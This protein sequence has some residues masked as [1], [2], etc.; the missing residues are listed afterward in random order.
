[1]TEEQKRALALARA[2]QRASQATEQPAQPDTSM[3]E[4]SMS[5]VNDSQPTADMSFRGRIRDNLLGVDDGVQSFGEKMAAGVNKF[6]E[7][8]TLGLAGD[9]AN[10]RADALMGRGRYSDRLNHYRNQQ[11]TFERENPG[12]ALAA[13]LAPALVPGVGV[14]GVAAKGASTGARMIRGALAGGAG[15]TVYGGM[16]GEGGFDQRLENARKTAVIGAGLGASG[17]LATNALQRL[18]EGYLRRKAVNQMV[19]DAPSAEALEG[20]A[21]R[22]YDRVRDSGQFATPQEMATVRSRAEAALR[23][24]GVIDDAGNA[25]E[26]YTAALKPMRTL[27]AAARNGLDGR[28][29]QPVKNV[30]QEAAD[31]PMGTRSEVGQ[32]LRD[33]YDDFVKTQS[34]ARAQADGL[35][36]RAQKTKEIDQLIRGAAVEGGPNSLASKFKTIGRNDIKGQLPGWTPDEIAA[37]QRVSNGGIGE[38]TLRLAGT[39]APNSIPLSVL[40]ASVPGY[41]GYALGGVPGAFAAGSGAWAIG[42]GAKKLASSMQMR[43]AEVAKA[44]AATG[45][46]MPAPKLD[47]LRRLFLDRLSAGTSPRAAMALSQQ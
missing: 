35:Y 43:N 21:G 39:M 11:E 3:F 28:Q 37:A 41:V 27:D 8:L 40:G 18:W 9:E 38:K 1:M 22:L 12:F 25:L 13:D 47:A 15:G 42:N 14:A 4:Q 16:E 46:Q 36:S 44:L 31:S 2:R 17:P 33:I 5:G 24:E 26:G 30:L 6:A 20:Q 23:R 34:P 19:R 29:I 32:I 45:S 10:A 7:S